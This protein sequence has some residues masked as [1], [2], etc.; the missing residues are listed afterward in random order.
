MYAK[1]QVLELGVLS[2]LE[3][4]FA[5]AYPLLA[6]FVAGE[7]LR[8]EAK[9][10]IANASMAALL[11]HVKQN[12]GTA[13]YLL[14]NAIGDQAEFFTYVDQHIARE[15]RPGRFKSFDGD[16]HEHARTYLRN[17]TQPESTQP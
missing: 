6:E 12:T 15:G 3:G 16:L 11:R 4:L 13:L 14:L 10:V 5:G 8:L 17:Q 7:A 2:D 1:H 9:Q